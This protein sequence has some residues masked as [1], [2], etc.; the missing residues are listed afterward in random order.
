MGKRGSTKKKGRCPAASKGKENG[1]V[2]VALEQILNLC[3]G[4]EQENGGFTNDFDTG[5][6]LS[7]ALGVQLGIKK[8]SSFL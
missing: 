2:L 8:N 1:Y 4:R 5:Q 6:L 7:S 3:S